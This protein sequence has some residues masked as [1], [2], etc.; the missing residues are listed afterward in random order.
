M[1]PIS[2][3]F[4]AALAKL[5]EPVIKDSYNALK[6]LV[7][8]KFGKNHD[9]ITAVEQVEKKPDSPGRQ[10]TLREEVATSG[11]ANDDEI[12]KAAQALIERIQ[13]QPGGQQVIQQTVTGNRNIFSAT[14]DVIVHPKE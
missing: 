9:V 4:I 7:A 1:D 12:V 13:V 6:N 2:T 14:G 8:S 10:E 5:S 11:A 3:A